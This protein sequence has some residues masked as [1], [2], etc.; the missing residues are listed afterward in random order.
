MNLLKKIGIFSILSVLSTT[1]FAK[2]FTFECLEE[3]KINY[4][5]D[6]LK[7]ESVLLDTQNFEKD[8]KEGI[9]CYSPATFSKMTYL[10]S[11]YTIKEQN[12]SYEN[13]I[14]L[15]E[16]AYFLNGKIPKNSF[17]YSSTSI[18]I[19]LYKSNYLDDSDVSD[20]YISFEKNKS[21]D[22]SI[23]DPLS[24]IY[25]SPYNF[26][27]T[28]ITTSNEGNT[29]NILFYFNTTDNSN[30]KPLKESIET[31]FL[32]IIQKNN[33]P[34]K[35]QNTDDMEI[36]RVYLNGFYNSLNLLEP[37]LQ[38]F[39]DHIDIKNLGFKTDLKMESIDKVFNNKNEVNP[40]TIF[41]EHVIV[42]YTF[43][44]NNNTGLIAFS[45]VRDKEMINKVK[46]TYSSIN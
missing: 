21:E 14:N 16:Q 42:S 40:F 32:N 43:N 35:L 37:F 30:I 3:D 20:Y 2:E 18:P 26:T 13:I 31:Y 38:V 5:L 23:N 12:F 8:F 24:V 46:E 4:N 11:N 33:L 28:M 36:M 25:Q 19:L 44:K 39:L 17:L 10:K 22:G 1:T 34:L 9:A 27:R 15:G 45:F 7:G 29:E 41:G 6:F